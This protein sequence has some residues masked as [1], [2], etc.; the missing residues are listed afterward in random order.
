MCNQRPLAA[1]TSDAR[2]CPLG[3]ANRRH[4]HRR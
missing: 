3:V 1:T 2:R 4:P